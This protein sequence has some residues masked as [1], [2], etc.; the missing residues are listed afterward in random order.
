MLPVVNIVV[1]NIVMINI[2][3]MNDVR[4]G[5]CFGQR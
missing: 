5:R 1:I 2:I 4:D 3:M